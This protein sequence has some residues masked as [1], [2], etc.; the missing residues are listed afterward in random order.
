MLKILIP[1]FCLCFQLLQAQPT[2]L[3]IKNLQN[4]LAKINDTLYASKYE[5]NNGEYNAFLKSL[6][7]SGKEEDYA[8]AA[9]ESSQWTKYAKEYVDTYHL[10][11]DYNSYPVVN[12]SYEGAV[13]YCKWLTEQYNSSKKR[14]F[15]K[16]IFRLP[17]EKEWEVAARAGHPDAIYPWNGSEIR[18]KK[19]QFLCNFTN[20]AKKA[21]LA[22]STDNGDILAP[23][24]SYWPNDLG[25]YNMSGNVAEM[26]SEKGRTKGG[27]WS[28]PKEYVKIDS[29]DPYKGFDTTMPTIGF[30][31]FM[32][33]VER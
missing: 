2:F 8:T 10:S 1:L 29:P 33:V 25:I 23:S 19:G 31:Y 28:D 15:E 12:I 17:T 26:L 4:N 16:V 21:D 9:I 7:E 32:E 3:D 18:N 14:K 6:E 11:K 5:V 24:N 22:K 20:T 27:S 13:L 30:R